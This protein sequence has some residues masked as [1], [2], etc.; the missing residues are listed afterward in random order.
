MSAKANTVSVFWPRLRSYVVCIDQ[1]I[2][3]HNAWLW[4]LTLPSNLSESKR[5]WG[6]A[7]E[8][9]G[10]ACRGRSGVATSLIQ[11]D[12]RERG[13]VCRGHGRA[14]TRRPTRPRGRRLARGTSERT[15]GGCC[16]VGAAEHVLSRGCV[17][18]RL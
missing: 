11:R 7:T 16:S 13:D 6:L 8:Q 5:R 15:E 18:S 1:I 9:A 17:F 2:N 14:G 10:E 4:D 3:A 12:A